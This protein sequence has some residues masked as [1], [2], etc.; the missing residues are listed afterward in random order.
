MKPEYDVDVKPVAAADVI[1]GDTARFTISSRYFFGKPAARMLFHCRAHYAPVSR[2]AYGHYPYLRFDRY[3][4][5][6]EPHDA[7]DFTTDLIAD[8]N[9]RAT[10]AVPTK[11]YGDG[12]E[13]GRLVCMSTR[14]IGRARR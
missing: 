5:N 2:W 14:A 11:R 12:D 13:D 6:A 9:G 1:A 3:V 4:T 8:A 10:I 7:E